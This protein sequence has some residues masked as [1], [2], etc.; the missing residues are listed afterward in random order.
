VTGEQRIRH[1]IQ[2]Q[3]ICRAPA[4][5]WMASVGLGFRLSE[6]QCTSTLGLADC[7]LGEHWSQGSAEAYRM[8]TQAHP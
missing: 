5:F 1:E 2:T 8:A 6:E 4:A 7:D 3:L